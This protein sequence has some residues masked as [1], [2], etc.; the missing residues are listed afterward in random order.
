ML[1]NRRVVKYHRK[2]CC[3]WLN[4]SVFC[5][6]FVYLCL[7]L[8][9]FLVSLSFCILPVSPACSSQCLI[10]PVRDYLLTMWYGTLLRIWPQQDSW[11]R[12]L[13]EGWWW[14]WGNTMS[15]CHCQ[16]HI[17]H[18]RTKTTVAFMLQDNVVQMKVCVLVIRGQVGVHIILK[19]SRSNFYSC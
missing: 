9:L 3:F 6:I 7:Y 18:L 19:A 14:L 4:V 5:K 8:W 1:M 2:S 15:L 12:P 10:W 13:V 16:H 17:P 11:M